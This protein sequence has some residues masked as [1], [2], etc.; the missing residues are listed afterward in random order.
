MAEPAKGMNFL[1]LLAEEAAKLPWWARA[2]PE[3][4]PDETVATPDEPRKRGHKLL[5]HVEI[6]PDALRQAEKRRL[7]Y[8]HSHARKMEALKGII[9]RNS[10]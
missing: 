3:R 6:S 9:G 4:K 8:M 7:K 1:K 5:K 2:K 10:P